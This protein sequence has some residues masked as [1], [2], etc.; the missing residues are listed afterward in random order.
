MSV[1]T[2]EGIEYDQIV[3]NG[4]KKVAM[5]TSLDKEAIREAY[6]DVRADHSET[7]WAVFKFDGQRIVCFEKGDEFDKFKENFGEN[8]RAFGYI[9]VQTGDEMSKRQK[10]LFVTWVG[11]FVNVIQRAKMSTDKSMIKDIIKNFAVELQ[12]ETLL[13]FDLEYF[14]EALN[15]AGG[16]N[17]GTGVRDL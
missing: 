2:V 14:K 9:R 11:P 7:Q 16:A 17:Y 10:F 8:E 13:E 6:E 3:Q 15:K 5:A 4:P 1:E 12:L